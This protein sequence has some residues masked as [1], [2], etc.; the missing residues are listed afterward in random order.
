VLKLPAPNL[1]GVA[2]NA[3]GYQ[4]RICPVLHRIS[5]VIHPESRASYAFQDAYK[6][7][8]NTKINRFKNT[9]I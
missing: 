9:F 5:P 4:H 7:V 2:L 3:S 6:Q 1:S 8:T